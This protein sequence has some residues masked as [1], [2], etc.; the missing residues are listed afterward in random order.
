MQLE[1]Q[2]NN[3]RIP[4]PILIMKVAGK[5]ILVVLKKILVVQTHNLPLLVCV[6]LT[7]FGLQQVHDPCNFIFD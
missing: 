7:D 2:L 4:L 1:F 3:E 5:M 6:H